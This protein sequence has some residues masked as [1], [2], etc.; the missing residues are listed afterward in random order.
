MSERTEYKPGTFCWPELVATDANK[1]KEF[2]KTLFNWEITDNPMGDDQIYSV[3]RLKEKEVGGIYQMYSEQAEQGVPTHWASYVSVTSVDETVKKAK[4]LGANI[5]VEPMDVTDAGRMAAAIDPVG[6][7][8]SF[9]QPFKHIGAEIVNENGALLWNELATNETDKA[10]EFYCDLLGWTAQDMNVGGVD[11]KLLMNGD[12][13]AGGIIQMQE[14]WCDMP[15]VWFVYFAADDCD[16]TISKAETL[17]GKVVSPAM[18]LEGI[19][20][21]AMLTDSQGALFGITQLDELPD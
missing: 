14:E 8:I 10:G 6:A 1:A 18:D 17:G 3:T 4:E 13:M 20:R 5:V 9:W 16:G 7:M 2:Y 19:G 11:Y 21:I 15:P 12:T